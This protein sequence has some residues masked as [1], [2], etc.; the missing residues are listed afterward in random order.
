MIRRM[1]SYKYLMILILLMSVSCDDVLDEELQNVEKAENID[2]SRSQDMPLI[3]HGV[4]G[5]WNWFQWETFPL[6]SVRGDDVNAAGDQFPLT[7]TDHF[8][9]DRNFWI[10]N[11]SWLNLYNDVILFNASIE[12]IEKYKAAG[13]NPTEADQ[14]I[15]EF[16]VLR[17]FQLLQLIRLWGDILVPETAD[18]T[19]L[20]E[21]PVTDYEEALRHIA[22]E[23]DEAIPMLPSVRPNQRQDIKGGVTRYTAYAIKAMAHLELKEY[24]Q[25]ANATGEIIGSGLFSLMPDF[26]QL[27]KIPGK[28]SDESLLEFQYSDFGQGSGTRTRYNW[29]FFG[30]PGAAWTPAVP[31]ASGGWGF[32]E[33]STKF[34]KFMLERGEQERLVTSVL[35]TPEGVSELLADPEID[36]MPAFL[37]FT[38]EGFYVTPD[39]DIFKDHPRYNFLSGKFYLP[40]VQLTPGRTEYGENNNFIAIRYA[41][42]LLMHAEALVGGASS[43]EMSAVEAVN[44]VRNRAGLS[45]LS[46]VTLDDVLDEKFAEF[47]TEWGIRFYDL[48]RHGKTSELDYGGRTYEEGEDR[49]LPYPLEQ[50]DVLP[51]LK[52][53]EEQG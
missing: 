10:Y 47:G 1:K 8:R 34:V 3:V 48:V 12:T 35:F 28:Y 17:G 6:I 13:A 20:L 2:F 32:W 16:K 38:S 50:T 53:V 46:S 14:F 24:Q 11:S 26:Y 7:E 36:E 42:I 23:M 18:I 4:Y 31:G 49:F 52:R 25:V 15:A 39:G 21:L 44:E 33:P 29:N 41:H 40:T 43:S 30:P 37:E 5:E 45:N 19:S 27:F 22:Q 9:Y 51:Q